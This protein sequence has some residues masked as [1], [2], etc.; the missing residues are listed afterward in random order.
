VSRAPWP[1]FALIGSREEV[2]DVKNSMSSRTAGVALA[3]GLLAAPLSAVA[4]EAAPG[5]G[6]AAEVGGQKITIEELDAYLRKTNTAAIQQFYDARRAAL[7]QMISDRLLEMEA[8]ARGVSPESL[9][10][11]IMNGA[12]APGDADVQAFFDQ[13]KA[14]MGGKTFDQV[15]DQIRDFLSG[16]K[17]QQ[18]LTDF[19]NDLGD[20]KGI[21]VLLDPPRAALKIADSEPARG[22]KDAPVQI[23]EYSDFQ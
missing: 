3:L 7:E 9:K 11:T 17:K 2:S 21:N 19:V 4:A 18:A 15:K 13:N 1:R 20:K 12:A 22:P 16:S 23:V 10:Q 14:R 5:A 6:V 8:K